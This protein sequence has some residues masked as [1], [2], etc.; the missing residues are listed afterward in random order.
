MVDALIDGNACSHRKDQNGNNKAP[1]IDFLSVAEGKLFV[2]W[3]SR[4]LESMEKEGLVA[5]VDNLMDSFGEHG[6][7]AG[8]EGG[9]EFGYGD[10]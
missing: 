5:R 6:G 3:L 10:Q 2:R 4:S 1:E 8:H 7:T 9:K